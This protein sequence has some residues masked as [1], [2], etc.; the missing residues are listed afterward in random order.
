MKK[1]LIKILPVLALLM[2]QGCG[3]SSHDM[4]GGNSSGSD[5]HSG[6]ASMDKPYYVSSVGTDATDFTLTNQEGSKVTLSELKGSVVVLAFVYTSC[7][8]A[9]PVFEKRYKMLQELYFNRFGKD[10][11][12]LL[13]TIDPARD[14]VEALKKRADSL[15]VM[16]KGWYYLTGTKDEVDK[17]LKD[18]MVHVE[19]IKDTTDFVHPQRVYLIGKD[20][21]VHY[22]VTGLVY[23]D[24]VVTDLVDKLL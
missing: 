13:V 6:H 21:K 20:G 23:P 12:L 3:D 15:N 17:V 19:R 2:L 8:E 5:A 11:N 9:C 1:S 22:R 18:Y 16:S 24:E 4:H 7:Q 10:L 14:T